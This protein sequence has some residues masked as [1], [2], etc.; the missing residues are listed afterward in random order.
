MQR[1]MAEFVR[2][3]EQ[4]F[5]GSNSTSSV[6]PT[7]PPMQRRYVSPLGSPITIE[8]H[9]GAGQP[10]VLVHGLGGSA[11]NWSLVAPRLADI[12]RVIA[13]DLPGHGRSG[14][15][16]RHDLDAHLRALT[17]VIELHGFRSVTLVGNSMGGLVAKMLASGRPDLVSRLVLLA[18]ATPP[19]RVVMPASP[20]IAARLAIRS[21]PGIGPVAS[22][23]L[24]SR[25]TPQRQVSETLRVVMAH[26]HRL[27][28]AAFERAVQ[29]ATLRR[30]MPWAN[31]A[32]AESVGSVRRS[33]LRRPTYLRMLRAITAP[34]TLLF[35]SQDQV[36]PPLTLRWLADDRPEWRSIEMPDAGHTPMLELPDLV[37]REIELISQTHRAHVR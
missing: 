28:P 16:P 34:T 3:N 13:I 32:F 31:R 33:L 27:P 9:G 6:G 30:T 7:V 35:G 18:P 12:G 8:D 15:V 25:W 14:P 11:G 29:L 5:H 17:A 37:V 21:L 22:A 20:A 24:V 26:P 10:I 4:D 36:V 1:L 2:R 23:V 19:P